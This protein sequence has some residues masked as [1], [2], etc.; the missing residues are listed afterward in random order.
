MTQSPPFLSSVEHIMNDHAPFVYA[1]ETVASVRAAIEANN[2]A[3]VAV[4]EADGRFR[5]SIDANSV[6]VDSV[7]T[8]GALARRAP[9][10]ARIGESAFN[11]VSRMLSRR[12]EWVP[13]LESGKLVGV[14]TRAGVKTAFGETYSA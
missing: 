5:G 10:T 14:V 8:A 11:I 3:P 12:I 2:G 4:I 7:A 13:V 1:E 9:L 6:I